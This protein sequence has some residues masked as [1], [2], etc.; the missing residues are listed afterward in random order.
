MNEPSQLQFLAVKQAIQ[1][2]RYLK[3]FIS[4]LPEEILYLLVE[5][6]LQ[7]KR[8]AAFSDLVSFWPFDNFI[9]RGS[10][11]FGPDYAIVLA[12]ALQRSGRCK[13]KQVDISGSHIGKE[14]PLSPQ[15]KFNTDPEP[16]GAADR[17]NTEFFMKLSC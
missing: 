12:S 7:Q 13:I 3:H 4:E 17:L 6:A 15:R 1:E 14:V 2:R 9:L 10:K 11:V 16:A 5:A 8:V